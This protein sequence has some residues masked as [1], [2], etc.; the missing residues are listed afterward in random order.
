MR[1]LALIL[2]LLCFLPNTLRAQIGMG[3]WRMHVPARQA[4]DVAAGN[5]KVYAALTGGI[6]EYDIEASEN[7]LINR[8]NGLSDIAVKSIVFEPSTNSFFIGYSNGNIDQVLS[9]GSVVNIPAIKLSS[10]SGNKEINRMTAR[11]GRVYVSTGF[12]VVV[13]DPSKSEVKDTWYPASVNVPVTDIAFLGDS[14]Y[15]LSDTALYRGLTTSQFLSN[16]SQWTRDMRLSAPSGFIFRDLGVLNDELYFG[17][18]GDAYGSDSIMKLT[19]SGYSMVIGS[20]FDMEIR[21]FETA[22]EKFMVYLPDAMVAY[23]T[24]FGVAYGI[25]NYQSIDAQPARVVEYEGFK[26]VADRGQ[27]LVRFSEAWSYTFIQQE[28]P[29]KNQF[30]SVDGQDGKM[31]VTG[32]AIDRVAFSYSLA[33]AY[34]FSDESWTLYDPG[35]QPLWNSNLW[36]IGAAAID[37]NDTSRMAFGSYSRAPLQIV[38]GTQMTTFYTKENSQLDSTSLNGGNSNGMTCISDLQFDDDGNLWVLNCYTQKPLKCLL[39]NGTWK[40][41]TTGSASSNTFTSKL[42]IDGAGNKWFGVHATGLI[43]FDDNETPENTAD[44]VYRFMKD[45]EGQGNLPSANVTAL[46]VDMDGELWIGTEAG[47]AI[48]YNAESA[49]SSSTD[50]AGIL[51]DFEGNIEYLLNDTYISDIEIDGGNRKWI[52]T[53]S[54]GIFV[55][56]ASGQEVIANYTTDNSPILSNKIMDMAFNGKTGELFIITDIGMCSFRTDASDED[57]SYESTTVFPNP[58]MPEFAGPITIQ[59]IRYDSDVKITDISG[60]L[61]YKT[62]SNGGTATWNGKQLDGSDVPAGVYLIWTA[63]NTGK[64]KKVGKVVVIR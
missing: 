44:D 17:L 6:V 14:V 60:N 43:G 25:D 19:D 57:D 2:L 4:I 52:A 54:S 58:V 29:P 13:L 40:E 22:N 51:I 63:T 27:G 3:Q 33:G 30:F 35:N 62:T 15:V 39:A 24:A 18:I 36:D 7:R 1:T 8:I 16:P 5:G 47:F 56:S 31:V 50:A 49:V 34:T 12:G 46:A 28:G 20:S 48:L 26:W 61:V 53:E 21:R 10:V 55:L 41:Y 64:N 32:G 45:G 23:D 59:G 42:A 9:S 37:P 38:E 11:N